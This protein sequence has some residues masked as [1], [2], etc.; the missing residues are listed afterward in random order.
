MHSFVHVK[1]VCDAQVRILVENVNSKE[2]LRSV[3]QMKCYT[4]VIFDTIK[5]TVP[6]KVIESNTHQVIYWNFGF[7]SSLG[8]SLSSVSDFHE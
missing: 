4:T 2:F 5:F 7:L 8:N 6:K 3:R 1:V